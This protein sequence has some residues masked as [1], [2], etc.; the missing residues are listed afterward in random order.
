MFVFKTGKL[1]G[2]SLEQLALENYPKFVWFR[3]NANKLP[4]QWLKRMD[5]IIYA[6]DNFE[7]KVNCAYCRTKPIKYLSI[8]ESSPLSPYREISISVDYGYCSEKCAKSDSSAIALIEGNARLWPVKYS[9]IFSYFRQPYWPKYVLKEIHDVLWHL[10]S[11][12]PK[13]KKT[14]DFLYKLINNILT[15]KEF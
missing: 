7:S 3:K 4:E 13:A 11:G 10:L 9:V 12:N 14:K 1:K 5:E 15:K 8:A 2:K 6:L